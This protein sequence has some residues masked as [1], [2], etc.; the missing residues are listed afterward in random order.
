M[1][2]RPSK[3]ASTSRRANAREITAAATA[4]RKSSATTAIAD[5]AIATNSTALGAAT[6][7]PARTSTKNNAT[8]MMGRTPRA[9]KNQRHTDT[10]KDQQETAQH[11][12]TPNQKHTDTK[13][14]HQEKTQHIHGARTPLPFGLGTSSTVDEF[15]LVDGSMM[16][17]CSLSSMILRSCP[18]IVG[19]SG[20]RRP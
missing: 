20:G 15:A 10:K 6:D 8:R 18:R 14:D 5:R 3:H 4:T 13:K 7:S 1:E 16:P 17:R 12:A 19:F 9:D 11:G 2:A